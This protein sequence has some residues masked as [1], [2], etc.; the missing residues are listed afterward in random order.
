[1]NYTRTFFQKGNESVTFKNISIVQ[2]V[3]KRKPEAL[4]YVIPP[5]QASPNTSLAPL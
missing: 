2:V 1:M 4:R 5:A 3:R